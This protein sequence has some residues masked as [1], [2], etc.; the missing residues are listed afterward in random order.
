MRQA[1]ILSRKDF[2]SEKR[3]E[4]HFHT[5]FSKMDS[6]ISPAEAIERA[7][8]WGH[9]TV[10]ITD[11][12]TVMGFGEAMRAAARHGVRVIWGIEVTCLEGY[13]KMLLVRSVEGL[14]NLYR[15]LSEVGEGERIPEVL[16]E[17]YRAG[18]LV[19]APLFRGELLAGIRA[20][21]DEDALS[22]IAA[23]YDYLE[24][25][26]SREASVREA[27]SRTVALGEKVG[28]PVVATGNVHFLNPEDALLR[29]IL[30]SGGR[31]DEA[32]DAELYL[33]TTEEMLSVF[34]YLGEE[35]AREVVVTNPRRI[36]EEIFDVR[37]IPAGYYPPEIEGAAEALTKACR[38]R[39]CAL[40]GDPLPAFVETRLEEELAAILYGGF[41]TDYVIAMCLAERSR[42]LGYPVTVRGGVG[43][44]LTAFLAGISDVNPLPAHY[45][46]PHC[47]H[48][49]P[50]EARSGA[51]LGDAVCPLCGRTMRADGC[52]IPWETFLGFY[53]DRAPDIDLNVA[54]DVCE[55]LVGV[56]R[57]MFGE[58]RVFSARTVM[59]LSEKSAFALVRRYFDTVGI[60]KSRAELLVMAERLTGVCRGE[61]L[62]PGACM[63][64]PRE[65]E[66]CD[67][68]P[69]VRREDGVLATHFSAEAL[70][71]TVLKI[72]VLTHDVPEK[73][74]RLEAQTGVGIDEV[75]LNE[76]AVYEMIA[77]GD[78]EGINELS[79]DF[80]RNTLLRLHPTSF[81]DLLKISGLMH[82]TD[83][84]I[85]NAERLIADGV[86]SLS[87]TVATRDDIFL[88]LRSHGVD[89]KSAFAVMEYVRKGRGV[90]EEHAEIM[91]AAGIPEWYVDSCRRI[92]YLFPKAHAAAYVISQ[93]RLAWYK[94]HYPEAFALSCGFD[95]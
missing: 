68:T 27:C 19:G 41:A 83:V 3:I 31:T 59:R 76:Q 86:C 14:K 70:I 84:W 15:M 51:D 93:V 52:D 21:L 75:P 8:A 89:R 95:F 72:D 66:I 13:H 43:A 49:A 80:V 34:S 23:R 67:F 63:I 11:H 94:L 55:E 39:A 61:G 18:L 78:T 42:E 46:C 57:E 45:R 58:D 37:P 65:Y 26:P 60:E 30:L 88:T 90:P 73:L 22:E 92:R 25:S 62:H 47:R 82:G 77:R 48:A 71:D 5:G 54:P 38:T 28:K 33:R 56:L 4:L 20:G 10:A 40:Y 9:G 32:A 50:A 69:I 74:H 1:T 53:G 7:A 24:I 85:G 36:D 29:E 64:V 17:K 79:S 91:R 2:A 6:V 87:E 35:K 81:S 12:D 44:T 16:I